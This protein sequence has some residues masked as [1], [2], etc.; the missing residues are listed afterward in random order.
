M[1]TKKL[2][3]PMPATITH[4][5]DG[6]LLFHCEPANVP[7]HCYLAMINHY[8]AQTARERYHHYHRLP[9][10]AVA[11]AQQALVVVPVLVG[12]TVSVVV[13]V[14]V[15]VSVPKSVVPMLVAVLVDLELTDP[16][17]QLAVAAATALSFSCLV[18]QHHRNTPPLPLA[19][20]GSHLLLLYR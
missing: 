5:V 17:P 15:P 1:A 3:T 14:L 9:P 11:A 18:P 8:A 10:P 20:L 7:S 12:A 16:L 13:T 2:L 4:C 19:P 6:A